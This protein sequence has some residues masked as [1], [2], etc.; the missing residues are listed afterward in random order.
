MSKPQTI[1]VELTR[2][3]VQR[4]KDSLLGRALAVSEDA[5]RIRSEGQNDRGQNLYYQNLM[6]LYYNKFE[7]DF[8]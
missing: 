2:A 8:S 1:T 4:I 5:K 7:G 3:E 6:D